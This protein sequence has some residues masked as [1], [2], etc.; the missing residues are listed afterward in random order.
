MSRTQPNFTPETLT[1]D[2]YVGE[3]VL[4]A[5]RL[6]GLN[7]ED[8]AGSIGLTVEYLDRAER[9]LEELTANQ[10]HL[11]AKRLD[12]R[13]GEFFGGYQ[14]NLAF[15][16]PLEYEN[17]PNWPTERQTLELVKAFLGIVPRDR[18]KVLNLVIDFAEGRRTFDA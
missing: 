8:V 1:I 4:T 18:S 14:D 11:L 6:L 10:L 12:V 2:E 13:I 3:R 5:R 7:Q 16:D 17:S 15:F 9:G